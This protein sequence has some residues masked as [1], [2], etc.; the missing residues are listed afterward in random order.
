MMLL[1]AAYGQPAEE[2]APS[3]EEMESLIASYPKQFWEPMLTLA[4]HPAIL[5]RL[6]R[7]ETDVAPRAGE[8]VKQAAAAL[9]KEPEAAK[10]LAEDSQGAMIIA[11]AYEADKQKVLAD[12][13]KDADEQEKAADEWT[14]RLG[15]DGDAIDQLGAAVKGYQQQGQGFSA[16]DAAAE[17]G[18]NATAGAINVHALPSPGF[19]TYVLDNADVY[20]ALADVMVSQWLGHRN[21]W[22]YDHAFYHWWDHFHHAFHDEHFFHH[23]EHRADRLSEAARYDRHFAH[24]EHRWDHFNDHRREY[25]HLG[26]VEPPPKDRKEEHDRKPHV[27]GG[28]EHFVKHKPEAGRHPAVH[29]THASEHER[30]HHASASHHHTA[31]HRGHR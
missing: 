2:T 1:A 13:A 29:R 12:I 15:S 27:D 8:A 21:S 5:N 10:A 31:A 24:D 11:N 9:G 30:A 16:E 28:G 14:K 18:V 6:A 7:K 22:A 23:D 3:V 25:E 19:V 26:K 17:A 4:P 20:P